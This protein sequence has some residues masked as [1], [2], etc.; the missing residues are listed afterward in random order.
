VRLRKSLLISFSSN[1]AKLGIQFVASLFIARLLT[2]EEFGIFSIAM[3]MIFVAD[4]L[5]N[6]GVVTYIVQEKEL[7]QT[8]LNA[9]SGLNYLTSWTLAVMVYAISDLAAGFYGAEGIGEVLRLL[10]VNFLL[11]PIG[12]ATMACMR[13]DLL[14]DRIAIIQVSHAV[15]GAL[16]S[17]ALAFIGFS[18]MS[19]AWGNLLA[20]VTSIVLIWSMKPHG[21]RVRPGFKEMSRVLRFGSLATTTSLVQEGGKRLPDLLLGKLISVEA[22]AYLSRATGLLELFRRLVMNSLYNVAMPHFSAQIREARNPLP[23]YLLATSHITVIGWPFY[24]VLALSSPL[25]IPFLFGDQWHASI[26]PAQLLCLGE[27]LLTPFYLM[28]QL[29]IAKGRMRFVT[30]FTVVSALIRIPPIILLAPYG[31][32][33]AIAGYAGTSVLIAIASYFISVRQLDCTPGAFFG[34][35]KA[36]TV[37]TLVLVLCVVTASLAA[38]PYMLPETVELGLLL[39]VAMIGWLFGLRLSHHPLWG[40]ATSLLARFRRK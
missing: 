16:A 17:V 26:V 39:V 25:L 3:V 24:L 11:L 30:Q 9:A 5:R 31:L 15:V 33:V 20:T 34:A 14:F 32:D 23:T 13:R 10:A 6:F 8:R 35:L 22:V 7:T 19:L 36:S 28:N 27:L 1:Y 21:L 40:E 38:R 29:L 12:A 37:T 18:Y 4:T 2:P